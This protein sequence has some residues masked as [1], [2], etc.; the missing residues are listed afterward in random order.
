M[1]VYRLTSAPPPLAV[2]V[3]TF[4]GLVTGSTAGASSGRSGLC[5]MVA[6]AGPLALPAASIA[7]TISVFV[8]TPLAALFS[9]TS[10]A[11]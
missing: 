11:K 2:S 7:T 3:A 6:I 5:T 1:R 10:I 8:V 4:V 9:S